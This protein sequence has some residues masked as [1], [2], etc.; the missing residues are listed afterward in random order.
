ME[1]EGKAEN[2]LSAGLLL[3]GAEDCTDY[4]DDGDSEDVEFL[5]EWEEEEEEEGERREK[6]D[7]YL[8]LPTEGAPFFTL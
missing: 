6:G 1:R 4:D 2:T 5:E 8:A 7:N 3:K